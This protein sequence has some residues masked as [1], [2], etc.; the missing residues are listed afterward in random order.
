[1]CAERIPAGSVLG[2]TC[3]GAAVCAVLLAGGCAGLTQADIEAAS[4]A[5]ESAAE[6]LDEFARALRNDDVNAAMSLV[7]PAVKDEK[8]EKLRQALVDAIW[9]P[10]YTGYRLQTKEALAKASARKWRRKKVALRV[11]GVNARGK[12]SE[13]RFVL[14][15]TPAGRLLKDFS[16]R[17]LEPGKAADLP[18]KDR[19]P[20][21][22][23]VR[24]VFRCLQE[25]KPGRVF[26]ALPEKKS[27]RYRPLASARGTSGLHSV[28][29][30]LRT[31]LKF[32]LE[33]WPNPDENLP[34]T[35]VSPG[36]VAV[37][38]AIPYVWPDGGVT[39]T[40][41]L[42]MAIELKKVGD[43]WDYQALRL[44]AKG[45]VDSR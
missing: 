8:R 42:R 27:V 23:K 30:D 28:Y 19:L 45:I 32:D 12:E 6:T 39:S 10:R 33:G 36:V 21:L 5:R 22:E 35:Y 31:M 7:A 4:A 9:H 40:D 37:V 41:V 26:Y 2:L 43:V 34:L 29:D 3:I 18:D 25:G 1:M 24:F 38:Y 14:V 20:V 44:S 16:I 17:R 15:R 11:T 13:D